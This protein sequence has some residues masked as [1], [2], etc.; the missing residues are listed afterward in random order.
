MILLFSF[1]YFIVQS[2]THEIGDYKHL[3]VLIEPY[4][5]LDNYMEVDSVKPY[6]PFRVPT[7][8]L[9]SD[10][11]FMHSLTFII[12]IR[13]LNA[14]T[15]HTAITIKILLLPKLLI[16]LLGMYSLLYYLTKRKTVSLLVSI[17]SIVPRFLPDDH[18]GIGPI[19]S[20]EP[21]CFVYACVPMLV[22]IFLKYRHNI[23]GMCLLYFGIGCL[24]NIHPASAMILA[25]MLSITQLFDRK[26]FKNKLIFSSVP[27]FCALAGVFPYAIVDLYRGVLM[28]RYMSSGIS[29]G[30]ITNAIEKIT[31]EVAPPSL[32]TKLNFSPLIRILFNLYTLSFFIPFGFYYFVKKCTN[33]EAKRII[34]LQ[35]FYTF[36]FLLPSIIFGLVGHTLGGWFWYICRTS[37][38]LYLY[39]FIFTAYAIIWLMDLIEKR[40]ADQDQRVCLVVKFVILCLVVLTIYP[41]VGVKPNRQFPKYDIGGQ[42]KAVRGFLSNGI[43]VGAIDSDFTDMAN[44][45]KEHFPDTT[46]MTR[47]FDAFIFLSRLNTYDLPIVCQGIDDHLYNYDHLFGRS[48]KN[49]VPVSISRLMFPANFS[50]EEKCEQF[51]KKILQHMK[52]NNIDYAIIDSRYSAYLEGGFETCYVNDRYYLCKV[53][54]EVTH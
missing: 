1:Y 35:F 24:G 20:S 40:F 53:A 16:Y 48:K 28:Q 23:M 54:N 26:K 3:N 6:S 7:A 43:V 27:L 29:L 19:I 42:L 30:V 13:V 17:L 9:K 38:L 37:T 14:V 12:A 4:E 52:T 22:L 10:P 32:L 31:N 47:R 5:M 21:K 41:P 33:V 15:G 45:A 46:F 44:Y 51:V 34:I 18:W 8:V 25:L 50:Y 39:I 2:Q 36:V 49:W 11:A